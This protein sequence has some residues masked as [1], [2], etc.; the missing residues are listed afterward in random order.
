[1]HYF[2]AYLHKGEELQIHEVMCGRSPHLSY[3]L[4]KINMKDYM[5][6]QVTPPYRVTSPTWRPPP[7]C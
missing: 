4:D 5:D 2:R 6:S 3:K 7:P 1:M